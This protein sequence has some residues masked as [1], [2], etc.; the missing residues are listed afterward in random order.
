MTFDTGVRRES[1]EPD[2]GD[3][4]PAGAAEQAEEEQGRQHARRRQRQEGQKHVSTLQHVILFTKFLV[5]SSCNALVHLRDLRFSTF[6]K[7]LSGYTRRYIAH[8]QLLQ[9]VLIFCHIF[10]TDECFTTTRKIT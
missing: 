4:G 7:S 3:A 9:E 5:P 1:S 8:A 6:D 2:A 10:A